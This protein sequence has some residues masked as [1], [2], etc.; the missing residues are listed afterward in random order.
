MTNKEWKCEALTDIWTGDADQKGDRLIPTGLLG[1]IRW[2]FEVLVRGLGGKAC[3][4]TLDGIRCPT[5]NKSPHEPGHHC[6]VCE[7]FGCTGW[8]RKFRFE[9]L[10]ENGQ[11][12]QVQIKKGETFILRF[13]ELRPIEPEE[14]CLLDLTL[15]LITEYGAIGG[16]TVFKPSDE[17]GRQN[18]FHHRDFGLIKIEQHPTVYCAREKLEEY[19][20]RN[21]WRSNFDGSAFSWASLANFWCV[22][23]RYL[24]RQNGNHSLFNRV[25]GRKERKSQS[26]KLRDGATKFDRWLAG[27]Q[28][29][30]KRVF[31]FKEVRRTFGFVNPRLQVQGQ[32]LGFNE[33]KQRL[34][35]IWADFDAKAEF[36]NG[37]QILTQLF[38]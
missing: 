23:E 22:K 35:N 26:Y 16:K 29:E 14:W 24:S 10:D 37:K 4:P 3:D 27:R 19:V 17:P 32:S 8:A 21:Q 5:K 12:K 1:S 20:K 34:K 9:V 30:S 7:L 33:M 38:S 2:W 36:I 28:Q 6:V 25:V 13:T 31:S 15:R 11:I 18:A